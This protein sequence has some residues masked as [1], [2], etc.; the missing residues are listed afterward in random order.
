MNNRYSYV[1]GMKF[2]ISIV[3]RGFSRSASQPRQLFR[4]FF[5]LLL[6]ANFRYW[7]C[8]CCFCYVMYCSFILLTIFTGIL[9]QRVL[10]FC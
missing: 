4:R 6:T 3:A 5:W 8:H 1:F 7:N 2:G 10:Q 9:L